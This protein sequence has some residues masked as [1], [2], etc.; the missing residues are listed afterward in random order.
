MSFPLSPT[1]GQTAVIN[2]TTFT[3]NSSYNTWTKVPL[4]VLNVVQDPSSMTPRYPLFVANTS[5]GIQTVS[6]D[7]NDLSFV[8]GTGTLSTTNLNIGSVDVLDYI[9]TYNLA[10]G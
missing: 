7:S 5:G 10:F 9:I 1:N 4:P 6:V 8:P 2:G 3:Y